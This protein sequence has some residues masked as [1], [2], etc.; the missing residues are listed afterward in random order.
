MF[1]ELYTDVENDMNSWFAPIA[2]VMVAPAIQQA[3]IEALPR[4]PT[5][6]ALVKAIDLA[7]TS[8]CAVARL[9]AEKYEEE[10]TPFVETFVSQVWALLTEVSAAEEY[11]A[12]VSTAISFLSSMSRK[13]WYKALF[14]NNLAA[15]CEKIAIPQLQLRE[16]DEELFEENWADYVSRDML[17]ADQD[18]RR[19]TAAD[20]VTALCVH[21]EPQV[22]EILKQYIAYLLGQAAASPD[23]WKAKDVAMY[24]VLALTV[25]SKTRARGAVAINPYVD[26]GDFFTTSVIPELESTDLNEKPIIKADCLKFITQFRSQL[27]AEA[28]PTVFALAQKWLACPQPVVHSYAAIAIEKLLAVKDEAG[29]VR[30]PVAAIADRLGDTLA[31][32]FGALQ[33]RD[34]GENEHVMLAILRVVSVGKELVFPF[35]SAII[36]EV[37]ARLTIVAQNPRQPKFNHNLFE[38]L[39]CLIHY[40]CKD[41][42]ATVDTFVNCFLPI[43]EVILGTEACN[44]LQPYTF[45]V[46][47]QLLELSPTVPES[48]AGIFPSLLLAVMWETQANCPAI[49]RLLA[50]YLDKGFAPSADQVRLAN[51]LPYSGVV[52]SSY[53]YILF[54][55]KC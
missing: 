39:A 24:V 49:A 6:A 11:D 4:G 10:F 26:I 54:I 28:L 55:V 29:A 3:T 21:F 12:L 52:L 31:A 42:P 15:L 18:T 19:R 35:A 25:K 48:F 17:G 2:S 50:A 43:F 38:V 5:K 40:L 30:L 23:N 22:T 27:P 46:L 36:G 1:L 32:L 34:S 7:Q 47:A 53:I 37:A 13:E 14:E 16:S 41:S 9:F 51:P 44:D 8:V 33:Q 45:Q 20:L